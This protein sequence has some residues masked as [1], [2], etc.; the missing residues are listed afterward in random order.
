MKLENLI[1]S[2]KR[3]INSLFLIFKIFSN[4]DSD[5][6]KI[7]EKESDIFHFLLYLPIKNII[8]KLRQVGR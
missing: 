6:T 1:D 3:M 7:G 8:M 2:Q 4:T 5:V